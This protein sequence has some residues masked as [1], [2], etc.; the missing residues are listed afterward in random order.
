VEQFVLGLVRSLGQLEGPEE[1]VVVAHR[2]APEWLVPHL[3]PRQRIVPGP[4]PEPR[5]GLIRRARRRLEPGLHSR[6]F[7]ESLGVDVVHFPYQ[8]YVN[9]R[10]P[11]IYNPHD[12]QHRC[13]PEFF[14][15]EQLAWRETMQS[16]GCRRAD[17]VAAESEWVR[18][19]VI[20]EYGVDPGKVSAIPRGAPTELYEPPADA[21]VD[22][23]RRRFGLPS[24]FAFYP[25]QSWPHK[26]HLRLVDALALLRDRDGLRV[27]LVCTGRQTEHWERVEERLHDLGLETQ[28]R[29]LGY[30][31][32]LELRALYRLAGFVV[33][34]SLFEGGGFPVLEAFAEGAPIAC[35]E[36]TAL[37]EVGGDAVLL[38]DPEQVDVIADA[39]RR[40]ATDEELRATLLRR[41]DERI[42]RF[43][44]QRTAEAYLALYRHVAGQAPSTAA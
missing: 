17:A 31:E 15:K 2:D 3:G 4:P 20:R 30:V 36:A 1:Y 37:P 43:R 10:L 12:L 13:F 41:G 28:V 21:A 22:D 26:N 8:S 38:F 42:K 34:P 14:T 7:F 32:P 44:W 9:C 18:G 29:H 40:M 35:A 23:V 16:Q 33:L 5:G 25:A 19:D 11:T 27:E 6:G 24:G 39:V